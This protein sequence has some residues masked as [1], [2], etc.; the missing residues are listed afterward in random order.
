M[1]FAA[2]R[3]DISRIP[4]KDM[5]SLLTSR[6]QPHSMNQPIRKFSCRNP[7]RGRATVYEQGFRFE[8]GIVQVHLSGHFPNELLKTKQNVFQPLTDACAEH[9]C[10]KVL[11]D[12]RD[13]Q[14]EMGT[15]DLFKAGKDVAALMLNGIRIACLAREDMIDPFFEDVAIN[16]GAIVSVFT[17]MDRAREWLARLR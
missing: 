1:S 12:A 17:E 9:N 5:L 15:M 7:R 6:V 14:V 3:H 11:I 2:N 13:L 10:K 8:D 16:R 4:Y